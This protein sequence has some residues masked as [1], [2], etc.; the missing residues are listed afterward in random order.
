MDPHRQRP[1]IIRTHQ[2]PRITADGLIS[3]IPEISPQQDA[4]NIQHFGDHELHHGSG[5]EI[6]PVKIE[7]SQVA[8][9]DQFQI[10]VPDTGVAKL[11]SLGILRQNRPVKASG[12]FPDGVAQQQIAGK[13][14]KVEKVPRMIN[15]H[16]ILTEIRRFQFQHDTV[17]LNR[18]YRIV[19]KRRR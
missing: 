4:W 12:D 1:G 19:I 14:F 6:R 7:K 3:G 8:A 5:I 18:S 10:A 11:I 2:I 9:H 15:I 16:L 17:F 13:M